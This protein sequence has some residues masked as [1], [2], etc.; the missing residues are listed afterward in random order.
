MSWESSH[1][2]TA[3]PAQ[4]EIVMG[5]RKTL[6]LDGAIAR[7]LSSKML[8]DV[9]LIPE[10][11]SVQVSSVVMDS[12]RVEDGALFACISGE[13]FDGHAFAKDALNSG[14]VA[15][16]VDRKLDVAVPQLVV[17]DV[18]SVLGE[19]AA[20]ISGRPSTEIDVIGITGTNGKTTVA[21][22]LAAVVSES[23][24]ASAVIGTLEGDM[25]TPEAPRLQRK[26][27]ELADDG[28]SVVAM[29][30]SSHS[31]VQQRVRGTSFAAG[32]FTNLGHDHLDIHGTQEEYFRAK[33]LLF[34]SYGVKQMVVNADDVYGRL[35]GDLAADD[36]E[37][38]RFSMAQV[39]LL[40]LSLEGSTFVVDGAAFS[41]ALPGRA[42][43]E[44]ALAVISWA[45]AFGIDDE[46][47]AR[48]LASVEQVPGRMQRISGEGY[49]VIVDF[50]H[51]PEAL[52]A[53]LRACRELAAGRRLIVVFGCG[54]GRDR[55]KRPEMA[56]IAGVHADVVVVTSDNPRHED[57]SEI[58]AEVC[59]GFSETTTARWSSEVDRSEAIS[60]AVLAAE[61]GDLII[62]AGKGH[63]RYQEI[64]SCKTDF[65]D[66]E[67]VRAAMEAK[68]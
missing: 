63:E 31:L 56:A 24:R 52:E 32:I 45:R 48:G 21:Q 58:I 47:I 28:V 60:R 43:V 49:D 51:T 9:R 53:L 55:R 61:D 62:I 7:E 64:G 13:H 57:P 25:T 8:T 1:H 42:N 2:L 39:E 5:H 35:L 67:H 65:D 41:L 16:L 26:L 33:S 23:G 10:G 50:A 29:E 59:A 30:V 11:A 27:R 14:A 22:L 37:V 68:R 4:S 6:M 36:Q 20:I 54:G 12:R 34:T 17:E 46:T 18:R 66:V 19:I 15:L 40:N 38:S 3:R 44:N